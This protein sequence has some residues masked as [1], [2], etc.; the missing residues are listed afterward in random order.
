MSG[1][2][3]GGL[4]SK[5]LL[6]VIAFS[7]SPSKDSL[8]SKRLSWHRLYTRLIVMMIIVWLA[9]SDKRVLIL[10]SLLIVSYLHTP[11]P[12][13]PSDGRSQSFFILRKRKFSTFWS[14]SVG[15]EGRDSLWQT[16]S[17]GL[18]SSNAISEMTH[19]NII[20]SPG[21]PPFQF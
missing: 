20:I 21:L 8:W 9:N 15:W 3:Q 2:H 1:C 19:H 4:S 6:L 18:G 16:V 7:L 11:Y 10:Y 17:L 14:K 12:C 13:H 5:Y